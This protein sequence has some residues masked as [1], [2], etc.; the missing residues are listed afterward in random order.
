MLP[1][2][3]SG[4]GSSGAGGIGELGMNAP[5]SSNRPLFDLN[6]EPA[7]D[8][9]SSADLDS[10]KNQMLETERELKEARAELAYWEEKERAFFCEEGLS[11]YHASIKSGE[12]HN[13]YVCLQSKLGV[14]RN[15]ER[16][17]RYL[18]SLSLQ[19]FHQL[20]QYPM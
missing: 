4:A 19:L 9:S 18:T 12:L 3:T 20:K 2:G 14:L 15:V 10:I 8:P 17:L 5:V 7:P 13:L 11:S 1:A 6:M 16:C